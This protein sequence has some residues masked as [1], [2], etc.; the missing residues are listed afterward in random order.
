M[1]RIYTIGRDPQCDIIIQDVRGIVSRVHAV[2]KVEPNGK[3]Y[4]KDQSMNGTYING[5]RVTANVEIPV[6]RKD[7][8]SFANV[9]DLDWTIIPNPTKKRMA[10]IG[11]SLLGITVAGLLTWLILDKDVF[12]KEPTVIYQ[13]DTIVN[14]DTLR[15][16]VVIKAEPVKPEKQTKQKVQKE[17]KPKADTVQVTGTEIAL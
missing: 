1:K 6:S 4:I 13:K 17:Q 7:V 14:V 16:T 11:F 3:M 10:I 15:D 8:I 2:L 5:M 12:R 9:M